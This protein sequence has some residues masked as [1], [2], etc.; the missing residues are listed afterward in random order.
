MGRDKA[1]LEMNGRLLVDHALELLRGL[2][3]SPRLC[4][5]RPDLARFA[6]VVPDNFP[7]CG[8]LAGIE[9]ALAVSDS[10]LNVFVPVDLPGLPSGFLR[11]MMTRA[12]RSHAVATIPRHGGRTHPLCAV[13]SRR[14]LDGLRR[15]L[16]AGDCKVMIALEDAAASVGEALDVFDVEAVASTQLPGEWPSHPPLAEWFRNVNTPADYELLRARLEQK[17]ALQNTENG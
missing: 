13:Y 6:G 1:L 15:S 11:W 8:P 4:G 17:A 10:D 7:Q 3:S 5:S 9:A 2:D 12:E 16:A 14:L